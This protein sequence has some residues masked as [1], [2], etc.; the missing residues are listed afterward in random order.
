MKS[1]EQLIH[2]DTAKIAQQKGFNVKEKGTQ[3]YDNNGELLDV[4]KQMDLMKQE[5][6]L[7]DWFKKIKTYPLAPTQAV[8]ARW[9]REEHKIHVNC[10]YSSRPDIMGYVYGII[11]SEESEDCLVYDTFEEAFEVGLWEGVKLLKDK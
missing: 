3:I 9:L 5:D 2:F 8:L 6:S 1:L 7:Q 11:E 10:F 4:V